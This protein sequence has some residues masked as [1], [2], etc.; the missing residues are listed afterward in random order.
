[1]ETEYSNREID[2]KYSSLHDK[3]DQ[4]IEQTTKH[5]GRLTKME[6]WMWTLSGAIAILGWLA[7]NDFIKF[8]LEK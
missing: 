1:M 8:V 2:Q 5:N 3:I 4:V 6:K 7:S